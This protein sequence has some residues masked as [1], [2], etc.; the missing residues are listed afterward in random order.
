MKEHAMTTTQIAQTEPH[1]AP[2]SLGK[3]LFSFQGRVSRYQ[4]WV[5]FIAPYVVLPFVAIAV[6]LMTACMT[7][8]LASDFSRPSFRC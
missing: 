3:F 6:D 2:P 7:P 1:Y 5:Q 4:Y 8:K